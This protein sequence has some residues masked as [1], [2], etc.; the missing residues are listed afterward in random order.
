MFLIDAYANERRSLK[1]GEFYV[2]IIM[3]YTKVME[4]SFVL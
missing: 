4:I 1:L 3:V 2:I